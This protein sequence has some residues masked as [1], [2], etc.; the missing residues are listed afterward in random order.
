M[1]HCKTSNPTLYN[2]LQKTKTLTY[3]HYNSHQLKS[4][5]GKDWAVWLKWL[6][7]GQFNNAINLLRIYTQKS[8]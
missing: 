4:Y 3:L 5:N 2:F 7:L 8:S 1:H 6:I